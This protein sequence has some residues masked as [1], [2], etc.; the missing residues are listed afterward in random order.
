MLNE[1]MNTVLN[2]QINAEIFSSYLYMSMTAWFESKG[3]T[4]F[5]HWMRLQSQ[6]EMSHNE[7]FL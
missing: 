6:E 4:G 5:A 1:K 3:L 7:K 2:E